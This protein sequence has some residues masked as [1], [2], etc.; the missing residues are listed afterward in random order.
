[1]VD[2]KPWVRE[3]QDH[4]CDSARRYVRG[5][6]PGRGDTTGALMATHET[7]ALNKE[8]RSLKD[9]GAN[10]LEKFGFH[11]SESGYAYKAPNGLSEQVVRDISGYKAEPDWMREFRLKALEHF[12]A[13]P[14]PRWGGNLGQID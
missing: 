14:T 3:H 11:D 12:R 4:T 8:Q 5:A 7:K 9:I 13:R 1:R 10:Y 2:G 6:A